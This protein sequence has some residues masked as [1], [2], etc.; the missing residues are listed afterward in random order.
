MQ[1][2]LLEDD[3]EWEACLSEAVTSQMPRQLRS[4]FAAL[5]EFCEP[6]DPLSLW[7]KFEQD[8]CD[9]ILFRARQVGSQ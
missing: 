2:G 4:L 6:T 7:Q 9:D 1:R 8:F 5:L 3:R